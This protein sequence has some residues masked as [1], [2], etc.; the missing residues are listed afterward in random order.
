MIVAPSSLNAI[1]PASLSAI[2]SV[3][4]SPRSLRVAAAITRIFAGESFSARSRMYFV[5]EGSSFTGSV[6]AMHA[7]WVKPPATAAVPPLARSSLY[8]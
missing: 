3:I 8:S 2:I 4:T 5:T 1:A 6:F 7:T